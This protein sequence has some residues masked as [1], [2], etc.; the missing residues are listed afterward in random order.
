MPG[1]KF[2]LIGTGRLTKDQGD[3]VSVNCTIYEEFIRIE[4]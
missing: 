4:T 2:A 1:A 3:I